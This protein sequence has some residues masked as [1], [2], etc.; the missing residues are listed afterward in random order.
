MTIETATDAYEAELD[1]SVDIYEALGVSH[2]VSPVM[3]QAMYWARISEL[4]REEERG[5]LEARQ[6]INE[7]NV[8]LQV[9][10]DPER[11]A[12]YDDYGVVSDAADEE[13]LTPRDAGAWKK[14]AM[15]A[16][17]AVI[18][19]A[20]AGMLSLWV[21]G[22]PMI[23]VLVFAAPV[24]AA[25]LISATSEKIERA[26][27]LDVL[28][29]ADDATPDQIDLAYRT[30][31]G[32]WL[33]R[34]GSQPEEAL[35]QLDRLDKAY[36]QALEDALDRPA[37]SAATPTTTAGSAG[38]SERATVTQASSTVGWLGSVATTAVGGAAAGIGWLGSRALGPV[39]G[40]VRGG[41][42]RGA[43]SASSGTTS[44]LQ[45]TIERGADATKRAGGRVA[46]GVG[47][48]VRESAQ[49]ASAELAA[50]EDDEAAE[51]GALTIDLERRLRASIHAVAQQAVD[52]VAEIPE[53][54][55]DGKQ[56]RL[57]L[58]SAVGSRKV[59]V[60]DHPVRLGNGE[61]ADI[62]I[63]VGDE[64]LVGSTLVWV[65]GGELV[66]HTAPG[67]PVCRVNG[68]VVNWARLDDGDVVTIGRTSFRIESDPDA[69]D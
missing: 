60:D 13:D 62:V 28:E 7:L 30:L 44:R 42:A 31:V 4:K 19:G 2:D 14:T 50:L 37:R 66:L 9:I 38:S 55:L 17:I 59:P 68:D 48:T 1:E 54:D 11:R 8:A 18:P 35:R 45:R 25:A 23:A 40:R 51:E 46:T 10:L 20:L 27:P 24:L 33:S 22:E 15:R 29:L 69:A 53:M 56:F 41:V 43:S 32:S 36:K 3:A 26:Q 21:T 39:A 58:E 34:V 12:K 16:G 47:D 67:G 5:D 52:H 64:G 61:D 65:N 49:R 63:D 57:V 6:R